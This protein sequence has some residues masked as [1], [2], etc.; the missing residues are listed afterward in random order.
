M[1]NRFCEAP[2]DTTHLAG[3][4]PAAGPVGAITPGAVKIVNFAAHSGVFFGPRQGSNKATAAH[5]KLD[6]GKTLSVRNPADGEQFLFVWKGRLELRTADETLRVGQRETVFLAGS[7]ALEAVNPGPNQ[8]VV[9]Q[10]SAR[11]ES[12]SGPAEAR[13]GE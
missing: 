1:Q 13:P 6:P 4:P 2:Q 3:K 9:I 5:W 8:T 7:E 12:S 11:G 10:V